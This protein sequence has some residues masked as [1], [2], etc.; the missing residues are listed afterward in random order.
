METLAFYQ[1]AVLVTDV[2]KKHSAD[3]QGGGNRSGLLPLE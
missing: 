1:A 2:W 3:E